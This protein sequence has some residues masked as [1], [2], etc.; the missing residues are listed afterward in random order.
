MRA[1]L[2]VIG[3]V[4]MLASTAIAQHYPES[5]VAFGTQWKPVQ[6]SLGQFIASGL[7]LA[8]PEN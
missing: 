4:M 6:G 7:K 8:A 2:P 3:I 1:P 5:S